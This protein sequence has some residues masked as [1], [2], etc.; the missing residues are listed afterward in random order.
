MLRIIRIRNAPRPLRFSSR[1]SSSVPKLESIF[2]DPLQAISE[3]KSWKT[4]PLER[5]LPVLFSLY[6]V[7]LSPRDHLEIY[8]AFIQEKVKKKESM[9]MEKEAR[10]LDKVEIIKKLTAENL[11]MK[12]KLTV[13]SIIGMLQ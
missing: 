2:L 13:R 3:V 10:I 5:R 8:S 11:K 12:R 4:V 1:S 7:R 9:I 6:Q